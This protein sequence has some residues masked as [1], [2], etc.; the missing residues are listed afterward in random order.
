[1]SG[2]PTPLSFLTPNLFTQSFPTSNNRISN[3]PSSQ[4]AQ[5]AKETRVVLHPRLP[6]LITAFLRHKRARGSDVEK[7]L[8]SRMSQ[9]EF[10]ARLIKKRPLVFIDPRDTTFT[11]DG[12]KFSDPREWDRVGTDNEALNKYLKLEQYMSY[13]EIMLSSLI[14]V[15]SPTYFINT[16]ARH[17]RGRIDASKPHQAR[18]I[19]IGLVGARFE[20]PDRMDGV[21]ILPEPQSPGSIIQDPR[22]SAIFEAWFGCVKRT[23]VGFN[24]E[25]YKARMRISIDTLLL[26]ADDR[27]AEVSKKAYIHATG[28][29]LGVWKYHENQLE[30]FVEAYIEALRNLSLKH[31][32]VLEM[33]WM[34][35]VSEQNKTKLIAAGKDVGIKV[36]FNQRDPAAKLDGDELLVM[37]FAWDGNSFPGNEYWYGQSYLASSAD[38]AAACCSTIAEL[39]N[40]YI[41]PFAHR[42]KVPLDRTID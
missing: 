2:D 33:A 38:P 13:D 35:Q 15:S 37:S 19:I 21:Y 1:M 28:L 6:E 23:G 22:L 31:V 10:V 41:N 36:L 27:A 9:P 5:D 30:W 18:G 32:N 29:G 3:F 39:Q 12:D 26:E 17:N 24:V 40:P 14:A 20:R 8:Y 11:R 7:K 16:G 34:N 42:I 25:M 4:I